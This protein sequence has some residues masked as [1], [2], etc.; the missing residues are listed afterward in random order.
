MI[1]LTYL[2]SH[3]VLDVESKFLCHFGLT[4]R[5]KSVTGKSVT[6]S[7][8][9]AYRR[10]RGKESLIVNFGTRKKS[11]FKAISQNYEKP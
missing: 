9:N 4:A 7:A 3:V 1:D 6:V 5:I 11:V 10:R 2:L 8:E